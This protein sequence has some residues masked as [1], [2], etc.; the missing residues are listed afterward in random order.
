MATKLKLEIFR[1]S[2]KKKNGRN[3]ALYN[4][5]EL[6]DNINNL[7]KKNAYDSFIKGFIDY[8]AS[9]FKTNR[10]GDKGL[11]TSKSNNYKIAVGSNVINGEVFGG[12]TDLEKAVYKIKNARKRTKNVAKDEISTA[13]FFFK[14]W[15]PFNHDTGVLMVQS[16]SNETI[17]ELI[18]THLTKFVQSF[19]YSLIITPYIPDFV[20]KAYKDKSN[21]NKVT[22]VKERLNKDKR[23]ILNPLFTEFDNLKIR[24]EVSG[25]KES[26]FEFWDKFTS[27]DKT[28]G[29]NLSD[30]GME[31]ED[32]YEVIAHYIDDEGHTS[33]TSIAK[34]LNIN[35]TIFLPEEIKTASNYYDLTKI[36]N[37]T[38]YILNKIKEEIK[39]K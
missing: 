29:A 2:L 22:Y 23:K 33:Q 36:I 4:F 38:D 30:L 28:M 16:Y 13:P 37:H 15:T 35:P 21:V 14:L 20:A 11:S 19:G 25:F 24:I 5:K 7:S 17:T 1:V 8:F 12:Q 6:F 3:V 26:I 32:D 27:G 34:N 9:E 39:I 18:K 31:E 10:D